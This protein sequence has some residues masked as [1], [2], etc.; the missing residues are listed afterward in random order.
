MTPSEVHWVRHRHPTMTIAAFMTMSADS[1]RHARCPDCGE[2]FEIPSQP[3]QERESADR[4]GIA[5]G[6]T[7]VCLWHLCGRID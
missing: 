5:S 2:R 4:S 6:P 7:G 3:S 1:I